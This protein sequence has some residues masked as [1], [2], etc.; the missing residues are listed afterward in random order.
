MMV[1][2]CFTATIYITAVKDSQSAKEELFKCIS[3]AFEVGA[4]GSYTK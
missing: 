2:Q 1:F 3:P 4:I